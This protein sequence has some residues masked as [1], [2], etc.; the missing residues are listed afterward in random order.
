MQEVRRWMAQI[1]YKVS[2]AAGQVLAGLC[3]N[4]DE[5]YLSKLGGANF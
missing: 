2:E 1:I 3:L 5:L 4:V